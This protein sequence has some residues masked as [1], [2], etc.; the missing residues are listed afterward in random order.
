MILVKMERESDEDPTSEPAT[1]HLGDGIAGKGHGP[2]KGPGAD[3]VWHAGRT[4]ETVAG[5]EW[6]TREREVGRAGRGQ[7]RSYRASWALGRTQA[8]I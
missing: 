6:V 3:P 8:L 1:H 2:C 5:A 4:Q 7:G